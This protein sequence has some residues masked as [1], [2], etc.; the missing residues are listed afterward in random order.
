MIGA[1]L[2]RSFKHHTPS[3]LLVS[4]RVGELTD[5]ILLFLHQKYVISGSPFLAAD[6]SLLKGSAQEHLPQVEFLKNNTVC[7]DRETGF[8]KLKWE[9][10]VVISGGWTVT[11]VIQWF[12]TSC[13]LLYFHLYLNLE[14]GILEPTG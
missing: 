12:D 13:L 8:M 14:R 6:H 3:L 5:F 9:I 1:L 10:F 2:S 11:V 4:P 7:V